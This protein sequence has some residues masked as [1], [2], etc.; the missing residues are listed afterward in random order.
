MV[1]TDDVQTVQAHQ[2]VVRKPVSFCGN[3]SS[4]ALVVQDPP[5]LM[6]PLGRWDSIVHICYSLLKIG[7]LCYS[8]T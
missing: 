7:L 5:M 6:T 4:Q 1:G 2:R 3:Y 8:L